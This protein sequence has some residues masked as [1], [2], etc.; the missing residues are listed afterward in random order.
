MTAQTPATQETAEPS[1]PE[2]W[3]YAEPTPATASSRPAT[4]LLWRN[5][6]VRRHEVPG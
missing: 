1:L 6:A 5:P 4:S 3:S 2:C